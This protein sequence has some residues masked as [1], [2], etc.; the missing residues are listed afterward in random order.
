[1]GGV[2]PVLGLPYPTGTDRV[3]D[4]DNAIQA[5]ADKIEDGAPWVNWA[6]FKMQA[7]GV[8]LGLGTGVYKARY[9][10]P[11][12]RTVEY[13]GSA[14][15]V[16]AGSNGG[17]GQIIVP[18]SVVPFPPGM[19]KYDDFGLLFGTCSVSNPV[20]DFAGVCHVWTPNSTDRGIYFRFPQE[21][22]NVSMGWFSNAPLPSIPKCWDS[23][24]ILRD[25]AGFGF[26]LRAGV[27]P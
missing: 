2:T 19:T 14:T 25:G 11:D 13:Q 4:G 18:G 21:Q 23:S 17:N 6:N 5:L 8:D 1:M 12:E 10:F 16:G 22:A 27:K 26:K 15:F 20:T 7:T 3:A 9:R 24:Y